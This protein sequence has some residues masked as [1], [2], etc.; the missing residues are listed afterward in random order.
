MAATFGP[1][2][3]ALGIYYLA[4]AVN[5]DTTFARASVF[6]RYLFAGMLALNWYRGVIPSGTFLVVAVPDIIGAF[7]MSRALEREEKK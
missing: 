1:A 7:M 3:T 5:N 2:F 6:G 4:A